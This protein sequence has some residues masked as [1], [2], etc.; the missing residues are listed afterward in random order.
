MNWF[1][2][3]PLRIF[4]APVHHYY[5]LLMSRGCKKANYTKQFNLRFYFSACLWLRPWLQKLLYGL[6]AIFAGWIIFKWIVGTS[7]SWLSILS[8]WLSLIDLKVLPMIL[9]ILVENSIKHGLSPKKE[10]GK[11]SIDIYKI[12]TAPYL[13]QMLNRDNFHLQASQ[14]HLNP[15]LSRLLHKLDAEQVLIHSQVIQDWQSSIHLSYFC[16]ASWLLHSKISI[17]IS[18]EFKLGKTIF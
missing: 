3:W 13:L 10:G 2:A 17:S 9:Q 4:L 18:S 12:E 6:A 1:Y 8:Y 15:I 14:L 11:V 16:R 5:F 7:L